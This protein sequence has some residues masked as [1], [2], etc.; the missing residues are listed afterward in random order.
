MRTHVNAATIWIALCIGLSLSLPVTCA[1]A[2]LTVTVTGDWRLGLTRQNLPG[3]PGSDLSAV[4]ESDP[5]RALLT[6]S[7]ASSSNQRWRVEISRRDVRWHPALQLQV[8]RVGNGVG[9]GVLR[10]GLAYQPIDTTPGDIL[11]GCGNRL[12]VPLQFRLTGFS[13]RVPP[14]DYATELTYT[15]VDLQ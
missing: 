9:A 2:A 10:S 13:V 14:A 1:H 6:V 3:R 5:G 12:Q 11:I 8:R 15:V 4:C 7:G